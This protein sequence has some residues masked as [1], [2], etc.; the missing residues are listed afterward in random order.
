MVVAKPITKFAHRITNVEEI[1]RI[2]AHGF[3][4]ATSGA[5]GPVLLDFPI[6]VLFSPPNFSR[7]SWGSINRPLAYLPGP[8][9]RAIEEVVSLWSQSERPVIIT[10]TGARGEGFTGGLL[11]LAETTNTPVFYSPKYGSVMPKDHRLRGGPAVRLALLPASGNKQPDLIILLGARSGFLLGGRTGAILPNGNCKFI[12]VDVDGAE[13]GKSHHI[14]CGIV[15]S[16]ANF[17][18]TILKASPKS[19][20]SD[21]WVKAAGSLKD[22]KSEFED[23]PKESGDGRMHPYH[24]MT[25]LF[26]ALPEGCI[27]CIDG[28]EAGGWALQNLEKARA[29][30]AMVTTGYLGFLGNGMFVVFSHDRANMNQV[31]AIPWVQLLL[32]HRKQSSTCKVMDQ[33]AF[34]LLSLTPLQDSI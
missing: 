34:I 10:G 9:P 6:D 14:D 7:I 24:A 29:S 18:E 28:G 13:I 31:G 5:P 19:Q 2:V 26:K 23:Q 17:V 8:D 11:K 25:T 22:L 20:S 27:V 4:V 32:I 33:L 30:L 3:R 16:S 1:P 15:S 21:E 12:H